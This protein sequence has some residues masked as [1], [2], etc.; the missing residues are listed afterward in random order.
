[1]E[2]VLQG[3]NSK[4][5]FYSNKMAYEILFAKCLLQRPHEVIKAG[6]EKELTGRT[7]TNLHA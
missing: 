6:R 3:V 7:G 2:S 5:S 4:S 1:M